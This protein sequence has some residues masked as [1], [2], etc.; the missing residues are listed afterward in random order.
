M[1]SFLSIMVYER[2]EE[3]PLAQKFYYL[4]A[5]FSESGQC[6]AVGERP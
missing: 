2:F 5:F 3:C 1:S 6:M 4:H